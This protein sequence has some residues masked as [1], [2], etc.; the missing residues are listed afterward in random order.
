M[1]QSIQDAIRTTLLRRAPLAIG[2]ILL[3][4]VL[5][6]TGLR[7]GGSVLVAL[8]HR[9]GAVSK[10]EP[11]EYRIF[12]LGESTTA[13]QYPP[14]LEELLNRAGAGIKFRVIDGGVPGANTSVLMSRLEENLDAY[15]PDMVIAMMGC[16]DKRVLYYQDIRDSGSWLFR[17]CRAYRFVRLLHTQL[18][19]KK[20][21]NKGL[22]RSRSRADAGDSG[23][24]A[25]SHIARGELAK[26]EKLLKK[27]V[28]RNP[29]YHAAHGELGWFQYKYNGNF[30]E[31]ERSFR[32]SMTFK[33]NSEYTWRFAWL[34]RAQG[35]LA[36]SEKIL[37][38][39][40]EGNPEDWRTYGNLAVIYRDMGKDGLS[41]TY[42]EKAENLK[43]KYYDPVMVS[44]YHLLRRI[45]AKRKITL[46][47]A[48]YPMCDIAPLK[49]IFEEERAG[50]VVFVDNEKLFK[51]AVAK[52]SYDDYFTD[53]F[54]GSFGHCSSAGNR[55]LAGNMAAVIL[56][57]VFGKPPP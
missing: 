32:K 33:P 14:F 29:A 25:W 4:A 1:R 15:K 6:E 38:K 18:F 24:L 19:R 16:N 46:V 35:K 51:D 26:A 54:G 28:K 37:K 2:G 3:T 30:A 41:R 7:V 55:L 8:Q 31:S 50:G 13:R 11:G 36:E 49:K 23:Q 9:G 48:Q 53:M 39:A 44:N 17:H 43:D 20:P 34:Y 42:A 56:K 40:L 45:L 22:S 47:S 10:K 21:G 57:E 12:C 27:D 5:L 52:G